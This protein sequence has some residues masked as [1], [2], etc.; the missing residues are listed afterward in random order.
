MAAAKKVMHNKKKKSYHKSLQLLNNNDLRM[1]NIHIKSGIFQNRK[2]KL[3][4][5]PLSPARA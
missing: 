4:P 2:M 5:L 3:T 1:F